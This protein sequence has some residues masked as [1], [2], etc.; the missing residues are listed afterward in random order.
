[1]PENKNA[2]AGFSDRINRRKNTPDDGTWVE[3]EYPYPG[4]C[5]SAGCKNAAKNRHE[6]GYQCCNVKAHISHQRRCAEAKSK[7]KAG[8]EA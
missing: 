5:Q 1:M 4:K 3:L 2:N 8:T 6:C 7:A